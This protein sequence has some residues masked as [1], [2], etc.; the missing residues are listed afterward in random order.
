MGGM[1]RLQ[2]GEGTKP[3][4][5]TPTLVMA[6]YEAISRNA[7]EPISFSFLFLNFVSFTHLMPLLVF[8]TNRLAPIAFLSQVPLLTLLLFFWAAKEK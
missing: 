5:E 8:F 4:H 6:R 3:S 1:L 7:I 2:S